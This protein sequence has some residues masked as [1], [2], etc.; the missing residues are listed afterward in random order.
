[1]ANANVTTEHKYVCPF[2]PRYSEI[3]AGDSSDDDGEDESDEGDESDD[4]NEGDNDSS[5][6][7]NEGEKAAA[8]VTEQ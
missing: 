7:E 5:D 4:D 8:G 6:D 2:H 1:M 3:S